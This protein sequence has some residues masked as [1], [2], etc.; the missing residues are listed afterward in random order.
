DEHK[1]TQL[2]QPDLPGAAPEP[3]QQSL[4]KT[5]SV[6]AENRFAL[7]D[8]LS[9]TLGASYDWRDLSRVEEYDDDL[10][11]ALFSFP[12]KNAE[13]WNAQGRLNWEGAD[14]STAYASA[15]SRIRFP[16]LFE[17]FSSQF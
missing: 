3:N 7:S 15:S 14:G 11:P 4:E 1:E 12:L 2:S 9:L 10:T 6:A 13:G 8:S 16:T 5:W 17:R